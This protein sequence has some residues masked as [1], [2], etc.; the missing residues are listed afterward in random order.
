MADKD[1]A[2]G[3]ADTATLQA[4]VDKLTNQLQTWQAKATDYEKRYAGIDPDAVKAKLEDYELMR[5][6]GA[7]GDKGK[8]EKLIAD[9][10]AEVENRFK[11]HLTERDT[12]ISTYEK[13]LKT[14]R[15]T[16]TAMQEAAK[17]FNADQLP[18]LQREIDSATDFIDGKIVIIENGKP[19]YSKKNPSVLMDLPEYMEQLAAKYPSS[20]KSQVVSGGQTSGT[21]YANGSTRLNLAEYMRLTPTEQQTYIKSLPGAEQKQML[22]NLF[23][24][25]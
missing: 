4:Q 16:N 17:K 12:K 2:T 24:S 23:Q 15:V 1:T 19:A 10:T 8:I 21:T 14:L 18:L 5:K 6:E 20:A 7:V 3:G 25:R 11:S 9:K 13:E 22:N